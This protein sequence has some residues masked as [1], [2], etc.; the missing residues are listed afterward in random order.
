MPGRV[1]IT[2]MRRST[3][4]RQLRSALLQST[5]I[6]LTALLP[7]SLV[8]QEAG[9]STEQ[10]AAVAGGEATDSDQMIFQLPDGYEIEKVVDA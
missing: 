7:H 10:P 3:I 5:A 9:T 1:A 6:L 2:P 8:A 4:M